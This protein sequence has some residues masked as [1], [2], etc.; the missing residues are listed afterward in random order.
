MSKCRVPTGSITN[1]DRG[2]RLSESNP[3]S[4]HFTEPL[5]NYSL[6]D[7]HRCGERNSKFLHLV[8]YRRKKQSFLRKTFFR[9]ENCLEQL[10]Q[11]DPKKVA[12]QRKHVCPHHY[13]SICEPYLPSRYAKKMSQ[14]ENELSPRS[15][16]ARKVCSCGRRT[17]EAV[18]PEKLSPIHIPVH[19]PIR[20][21]GAGGG[22]STNSSRSDCRD[23]GDLLT[24]TP[25]R[26]RSSG[27]SRRSSGSGRRKSS[28]IHLSSDNV[29]RGP[30]TSVSFVPDTFSQSSPRQDEALALRKASGNSGKFL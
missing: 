17:S 15:S 10:L 4:F 19:L 25:E 28:N 24:D 1:K 6:P 20:L 8:D 16:T 12:G 18:V 3:F 21:H 14:G 5:S 23:E 2:I 13:P 11:P 30:K 7:L 29:G 22:S 27:S 9:S 26:R